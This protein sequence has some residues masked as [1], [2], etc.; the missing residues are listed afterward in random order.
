MRAVDVCCIS[1]SAVDV[2]GCVNNMDPRRYIGSPDSELPSPSFVIDLARLR[3][4]VSRMNAVAAAV[5]AVLRPHVK[6]HKTVEAAL[7][8]CGERRS[9]VV[10]TLAEAEAFAAAG[11]TDILYG[12]PPEPS[13]LP[14]IAAL[15]ARVPAMHVLVDS[16]EAVAA[17]QAA[18]GPARAGGGAELGAFLKVDAGY[19]RAG[20]PA[21]ST[22]AA[23]DVGGLPPSWRCTLRACRR[24][25]DRA[26]CA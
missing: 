15:V 16:G 17:L 26:A 2:Y 21:D 13:K 11:F 23:V 14:R 10:S 19:G 8:Q 6:T 22:D 18:L 24:C 9:I 3:A 1:C 7:L 20:V 25:R 5:G 4:N 12:V